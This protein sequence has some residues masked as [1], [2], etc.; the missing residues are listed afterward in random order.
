MIRGREAKSQTRPLVIEDRIVD[1]L[2]VV[3]FDSAACEIG[4]I[5]RGFE[6]LSQLI[7]EHALTEAQSSD[8]AAVAAIL[9]AQVQQPRTTK[10]YYTEV[11]QTLGDA[12]M[13]HTL[14][15][16]AA[17]EIG[18][19]GVARLNDASLDGGMYFAHPITVG[20]IESLRS[21]LNPGV[22][23]KLLNLGI[24]ETTFA[25]DSGLEPVTPEDCSAAYLV[26]S[27]VLLSVNISGGVTR[28]SFQVIRDGQ[29][30]RIQSLTEGQGSEADQAL[31]TAIESAINAYL[32]EV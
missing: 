13:R 8:W 12:D 32:I 19:A 25:A 24:V 15:V 14:R 2:L 31:L 18:Q 4:E 23:D 22:A 3:V 5:Y 7:R 27:D 10:A 29:Q 28:C 20:L 11:Y 6:M 9:N 1:P 16:M 26:G 30:V 21:Q 17:D